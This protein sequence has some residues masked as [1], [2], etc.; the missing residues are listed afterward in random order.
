MRDGRVWALVLLLGAA[1]SG[2]TGVVDAGGNEAQVSY[3]Y[4]G[5]AT[6]SNGCANDLTF[7][8]A[9]NAEKALVDV[10]S[11][12]SD[13]VRVHVSNCVGEGVCDSGPAVN[14]AHAAPFRD[15]FQR[16]ADRYCANNHCTEG[17]TCVP[18]RVEVTCD[19]GHCATHIH[20]DGGI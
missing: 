5:C 20:S 18:G 1:C 2:T 11:V 9:I 3:T 10:C 15:A 6:A 13:C 14:L 4:P 17:P 19:A 16:E 7:A 8:C 12:P